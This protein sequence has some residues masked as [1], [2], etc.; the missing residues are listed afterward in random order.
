[1]NS[2]RSQIPGGRLQALVPATL[3]A[4]QGAQKTAPEARWAGAGAF[5]P[6]L[7][8]PQSRVSAV[9][10]REPA[11]RTAQ[12]VWGHRALFGAR[13]VP[14]S[15]MGGSASRPQLTCCVEPLPSTLRSQVP[16]AFAGP[17]RSK[18]PR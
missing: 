2:P 5:A 14:Q 4:P 15:E 18:A 7:P 13:R 17:S 16:E 11:A 10:L 8:R 3:L 1:M 12:R 6:P 9:V